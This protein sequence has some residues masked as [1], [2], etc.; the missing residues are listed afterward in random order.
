MYKIA[1]DQIAV[2]NLIISHSLCYKR[3]NEHSNML[4]P[5]FQPDV[6]L[7]LESVICDTWT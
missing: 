5:R 3:N 6:I 7:K 1:D 4:C 2:G